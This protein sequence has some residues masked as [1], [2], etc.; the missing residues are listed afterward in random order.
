[1][2]VPDPAGPGGERV[3]L[4]DFGIAKLGAAHV[5]GEDVKTRTGQIM[6]TDQQ[7]SVSRRCRLS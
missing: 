3:K 7:K 1:M 4:L 2:L 6:G 5:Q